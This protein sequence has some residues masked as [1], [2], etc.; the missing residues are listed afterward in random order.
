M[1]KGGGCAQKSVRV[2]S[3]REL[4]VL[5]MLKGGL[6]K[7]HPVLMGWAQKVSD[8]QFFTF[9][10]PPPSL[11]GPLHGPIK[12]PIFMIGTLHGPK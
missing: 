11:T 6:K 3:T 4:E 12:V 5:A 2:V 8:P 1:L 10:T 7:F 9:C